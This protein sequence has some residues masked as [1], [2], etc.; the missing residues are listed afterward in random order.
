MDW[1][2]PESLASISLRMR[3]MGTKDSHE[4][5]LILT[6]GDSVKTLAVSNAIL[7]NAP[8]HFY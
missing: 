2:S 3:S 6:K 5:T 7:S 1:R 8:L 4:C